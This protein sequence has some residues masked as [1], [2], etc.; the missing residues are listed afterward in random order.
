MVIAD[1]AAIAPKWSLVHLKHDRCLVLL[2]YFKSSDA[3][4]VKS[5]ESG[6]EPEG[7]EYRLALLSGGS[8]KH[9]GGSRILSNHFGFSLSGIERAFPSSEP[10]A[11]TFKMWR[12]GGLWRGV[13]SDPLSPPSTPLLTVSQLLSWPDSVKSI[14]ATF[15]S[16]MGPVAIAITDR[17]GVEDD[18]DDDWS[19][20]VFEPG[21]HEKKMPGCSLL[22]YSPHTGWA[23]IIANDGLLPRL[24]NGVKVTRDG[25]W[26]LWR[27]D[28]TDLPTEASLGE[29]AMAEL[30]RPALE[31]KARA[32]TDGAGNLDRYEPSPCGNYVAYTANY[33]PPPR[34]A[35]AAST[36][37]NLYV[38]IA[39][40]DMN[41]TRAVSVSSVGELVIGFGWVDGLPS[42]LWWTVQV[43]FNAKTYVRRVNAEFSGQLPIVALDAPCCSSNMV[44][45]SS[46]GCYVYGSDTIKEALALVTAD[47]KSGKVTG[48]LPQPYDSDADSLSATELEW[49]VGP[50]HRCRG[51]LYH[52]RVPGDVEAR[53]GPLVVSLHGGPC[54]KVSPINKVGVYGKYRDLLEEGYRVLVPAF[55]GTLGFGDAWSKATI[56]TQGIRDVDEVIAG[57][58]Y[59][60]RELRGTPAGR[61]S[62]V[63]GSY[64]GYL[65]LR[66]AIL[67][68]DMFES[69]VARYPW[70]STRWNGAETGDFTYEDEFWAGKS[71]STTW[72]VPADMEAS[73]ILGPQALQLI[74]VP[75]LIMHGSKDDVCPVSNSKVLFNVLDNQRNSTPS[76]ELRLVIFSGEGHGFRGRA[77]VEADARQM[78]WL[79]KV[80]V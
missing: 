30:D 32:I 54:S 1:R 47:A 78:K 18:E 48:K 64:G 70:V 75:L 49:D 21:M 15:L 13:L 40:D 22:S 72:P 12:G 52:R 38:G 7:N 55:S 77:R 46:N 10:H 61:V 41:K 63:G 65:A 11:V 2:R 51:M 73:D 28:K 62:L 59:L 57:I 29:L 56:G 76:D 80:N 16:G 43:G 53:P 36:N 4:S 35:P 17:L 8:G 19:G 33:V 67:H 3:A 27:V 25:S 44:Y 42:A 34:S 68:P 31:V 50:G 71:E 20:A 79:Q 74:N 9:G 14:D 26:A 60:Q 66:C 69:V 58:Q 39:R 24:A 37:L 23:E 45:Q 6:S 5:H